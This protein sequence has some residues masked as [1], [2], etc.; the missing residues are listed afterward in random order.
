MAAP[1]QLVDHVA[2][3]RVCG[4]VA[5]LGLLAMHGLG[6]HGTAHGDH[7]ALP[8]STAAPATAHQHVAMSADAPAVDGAGS[9][10]TDLGPAGLC[11]AVLLLGLVLAALRGRQV[12]TA[13]LRALRTVDRPARARRDRAPPS[14]VALS[15]LRC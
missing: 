6:L 7:A 4:A 1:R 14:L 11:L 9:H 5:L 15:I 3:R 12:L 8:M 2:L 13:E 10:H